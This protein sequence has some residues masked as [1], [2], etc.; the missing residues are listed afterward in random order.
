LQPKSN[1]K[2]RFIARPT[3]TATYHQNRRSREGGYIS[4]NYD[5][6][7]RMKPYYQDEHCTIYHGDARETFPTLG[8]VDAVITDPP[9]SERTHAGHDAASNGGRASGKDKSNRKLLGYSFLTPADVREI[10]AMFHAACDGWIVWM[11]DHTLAPVIS[12]SLLGLGRYVFAPLP[13]YAPGSRVRLSGDGPSSWTDWIIVARTANQSRWGTLPGGYVAGPG[14]DDKQW[15]GGKPTALMASLV[16]DYT[17]EGALVCDPFMGAGTTAVACKRL[18]RKFI[19][20]DCQEAACE[21]AA[22]RLQQEYLPL[23]APP[24]AP[25]LTQPNLV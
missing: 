6:L 7:R 1:R 8:R 12:D 21:R 22:K 10:S 16:Q 20:I 19:G 18:Y 3:N 15:I 5:R 13:F 4:M 25:K 2:M 23:S 9:Y 17:A 14:W 24:D 11:S